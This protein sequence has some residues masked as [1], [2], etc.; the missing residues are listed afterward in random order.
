MPAALSWPPGRADG[1]WAVRGAWGLEGAFSKEKGAWEEPGIGRAG[2]G[3][4]AQEATWRL[5]CLSRRRCSEHRSSVWSPPTL[6]RGLGPHLLG[7]PRPAWEV[8]RRG[9]LVHCRCTIH[10]PFHRAG[11]SRKERGLESSPL[12][13]LVPPPV[14]VAWAPYLCAQSLGSPAVEQ[15]WQ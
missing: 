14:S 15:E 1:P 7:P 8:G 11:H 9:L 6:R 2:K 5:W 3:R 4:G 12:P 10:A 13:P